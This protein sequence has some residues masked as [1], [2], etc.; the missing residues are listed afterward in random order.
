[1]NKQKIACVLCPG[2]ANLPPIALAY[3]KGASHELKIDCFDF[4]SE[5]IKKRFNDFNKI[6]DPPFNDIRPFMFNNIDFTEFENALIV[7]EN[8]YSSFIDECEQKVKDYNLVGFT[9]YQ[10]NII[11]SIALAKRLK[12]RYG[13][14][15]IAGGP[16]LNMDNNI[17]LE[18]VVKNKIIDVGVKGIAED[19]ISDLIQK[20]LSNQD[21]SKIPRLV[22]L[23]D[24]KE[25]F[26]TKNADPDLSK[27]SP[28][29]YDDFNFNDYFSDRK[30][31]ISIY[32]NIGC[33]GNCEFCT[34]REMYPTFLSKPINNIKQEMD[35][36]FNKYGLN[37]FF[38]SDSM[39]LGNA[40]DALE[41]FQYAI[42]KN[43]K[44]GIQIRMAPYWD[45]EELVKSASKCL[46]FLQIGLESLSPNVRKSMR[47]MVSQE[48]T[49]KIL[50]LFLKFSLPIYLNI[51]T[52]YPNEADEDFFT[53]YNFL[54]KNLKK[55]IGIGLNSFF[56]PNN[57]PSD[58]YG[59]NYDENGYW[60]S[61]VVNIEKR[62]ERIYLLCDL[63]QKC[64]LDKSFMYGFDN[65]EGVPLKN[66]SINENCN[67]S[68]IKYI[69]NRWLNP[70]R[71]GYVDSIKKIGEN[72]VLLQGW[73]VKPTINIPFDAIIVMKENNILAYSTDRYERID[74]A[75]AVSEK[76]RDSGFIMRFNSSSLEGLKVYCLDNNEKVAYLLPHS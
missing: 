69:N 1:M 71:A 33:M 46:Y 11:P 12:K 17:F 28:P 59:I 49:E 39:F 64:G 34:I 38:F 32:A 63:A 75:Q 22:F 25:L 47:K 6:F 35:F 68:N 36:L 53:T 3:I 31:V 40:K 52:G 62:V 2:W 74:V 73:G 16:S 57:F 41:L 67:Y 15:T 48:K 26:Y 70:I 45:N 42:E 58:K 55:L 43:Y 13:T 56:I 5:L 60:R 29:N 27:F 51:I 61:N 19:I 50:D 30:N 14:Y 7:Y 72:T 23:K 10:N 65:V 24:G 76:C 44:L 21:L 8:N 9:I 18:Y 20:I 54:K 4:N 66:S 37:H